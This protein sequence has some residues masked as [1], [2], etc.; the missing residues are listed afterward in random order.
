MGGNLLAIVQGDGSSWAGQTRDSS[1][2]YFDNFGEPFLYALIG[3]LVVFV[4]ILIIIGILQLVSLIMRRLEKVK[5]PKK[6]E[7]VKAEVKAVE[8]SAEIQG[9]ESDEIPDEVKAAI[10]AAIMAYY[11]ARQEKCEFTVKRIKRIHGGN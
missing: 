6:A 10:V 1:N 3:F 4:G 11:S 7:E 8:K 5:L 9:E 2:Y